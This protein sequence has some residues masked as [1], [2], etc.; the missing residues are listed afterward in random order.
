M[1][2]ASSIKAF[3]PEP[4]CLGELAPFK[5]KRVLVRSTP[6]SRGEKEGIVVGVALSKAVTPDYLHQERVYESLRM[7]EGSS[8]VTVKGVPVE[9]LHLT[10]LQQEALVGLQRRR[11][12]KDEVE[13]NR[14]MRREE[15]RVAQ[16]IRSEK[17]NLGKRRY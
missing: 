8:R 15:S 16:M 9:Y 17:F 13:S 7:L 5:G 1:T 3:K 12:D 2:K 11:D 10:F 4:F 6:L 14:L